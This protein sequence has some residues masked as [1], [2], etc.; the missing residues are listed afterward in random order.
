MESQTAFRSGFANI[1]GQPNVGKSTLLNAVLNEKI[2]IVTPKKQT[3]RHRIQGIL[4]GRNHQIVFSDTPGILEPKYLLQ[5]RMMQFVNQA[6]EDADVFVYMVAS[7]EYPEYHR[8]YIERLTE[9]S[10][11]LL[12][13]INK[14]DMSDQQSLEQEIEQYSQFVPFDQV[15]PLSATEAFNLDKL[16][17][18]TVELLPENPA[19]FP[20]DQITDK[21]ERFIVS[22]MIREKVLNN[23][24]QEVPYSI[25]ANIEEFDEQP[26]II[27]IRAEIVVNKRSQKPIIIGKKGQA[28]KKTGTEAR[29]DIETFLNK[30]VYLELFVKVR[31]NWRDKEMYLNQFGY[32]S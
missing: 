30:Q 25:E 17:A 31:E 9:K 22:E 3:T 11:P 24:K 26:D 14:I 4:T 32:R 18:K 1:I 2:S 21:S 10:I 19:Y 5:K 12:L 13:V 23:Y 15:I 27:N 28:L 7:G 20:D 16:I 8:D 6:M 29:K